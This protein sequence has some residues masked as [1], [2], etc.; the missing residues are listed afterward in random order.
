MKHKAQC[1]LWYFK[2][3]SVSPPFKPQGITHLWQSYITHHA[4]KA[5]AAPPWKTAHSWLILPPLSRRKHTSDQQV[6]SVVYDL[7]QHSWW[8][9]PRRRPY[10]QRVDSV[11]ALHC[12]KTMCPHA[13]GLWPASLCWE[14]LFLWDSC[15]ASW[16]CI[17]FALP[18]Q[19]LRTRNASNDMMPRCML[20]GDH[21]VSHASNL[22]DR[23]HNQLS[24]VLEIIHVIWH[25]A[26]R[27]SENLD[28][29][30]FLWIRHHLFFNKRWSFYKI[31]T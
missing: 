13:A 18:A 19:C 2:A 12:T 7:L 24:I 31:C 27:K 4:L 10:F 22:H 25:W 6:V 26:W 17:G 29:L 14:L 28:S 3:P 21:N 23:P 20:S 15:D 8:P 5:S 11:T 1:S 16:L 9:P 30:I